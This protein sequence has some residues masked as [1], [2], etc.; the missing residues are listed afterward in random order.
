[1]LLQEDRHTFSM[2]LTYVINLKLESSTRPV[3]YIDI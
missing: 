2:C 3:G 1:M